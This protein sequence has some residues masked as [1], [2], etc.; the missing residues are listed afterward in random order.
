MK[1]EM[2]SISNARKYNLPYN[3]ESISNQSESNENA[4]MLLNYFYISEEINLSV[5]IQYLKES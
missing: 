3:A 2:S 1:P 5:K 4:T